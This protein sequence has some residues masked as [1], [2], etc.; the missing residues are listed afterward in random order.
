MSSQRTILQMLLAN[1]WYVTQSRARSIAVTLA[2][3]RPKSVVS[4]PYALR[5]G[6]LCDPRGHDGSLGMPEKGVLKSPKS[7]SRDLIV[8][9]TLSRRQVTDVMKTST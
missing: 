7:P 2:D 6:S 1:I 5:I 8:A 9:A 4:R 3:P